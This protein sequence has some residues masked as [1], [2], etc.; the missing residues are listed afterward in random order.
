MNFTD[1][2]LKIIRF[3]RKNKVII[4]VVVLIWLV[5]FFVNQL[6]RFYKKPVEIDNTYK[7]SYSVMSSSSKVPKEMH[8]SIEAVIKQYVN[9]CNNNDFD[10]A[11]NMLSKDCKMYAFNNDFDK[12]LDYL[13]IKMPTPK[14]YSIQD[15]SNIGTNYI[16]SVKYTDDL[17]AT[18]LTNR[19]YTYTEEKMV[20]KKLADGKIEMSVGGYYDTKD[21]KSVSEN[22]YLKVDIQRK[23]IKYSTETYLVKLTNRTDNIIVIEDKKSKDEIQLLVSNELRGNEYYGNIILQPNET[24]NVEIEFEKFVDDNKK[25][26]SISFNNVR[27]LKEY[28]GENATYDEI[29]N[30][31]VNA[32]AKFSM[33]VYVEK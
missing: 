13:Y 4:M 16:Y 30:A 8:S 20:F 27:V 14:K 11:Y 33:T 24:R 31:V 18:G 9:Y 1:V 21:V 7:P 25:S 2:R 17:L 3:F 5:I 22:D 32:I 23:I 6:L 19:D 26:K 28:Y 10:M 29:S 12:Y 15:Y